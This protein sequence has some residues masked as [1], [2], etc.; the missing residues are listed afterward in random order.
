[1][2]HRLVRNDL[3][4]FDLK[5]A[6]PKVKSRTI[7]LTVWSELVVGLTDLNFDLKKKIN[8]CANLCTSMR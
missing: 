7:K 2:S 6:E 5:C 8:A 4:D 1:M 3:L